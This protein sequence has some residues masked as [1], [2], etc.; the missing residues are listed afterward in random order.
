MSRPETQTVFW[1]A[2]WMIL[3]LRVIL[4]MTGSKSPRDDGP[5]S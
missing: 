4:T 5:T 1:Q 2:G 3:A